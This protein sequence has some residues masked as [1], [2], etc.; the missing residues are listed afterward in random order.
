MHFICTDI[1][2][3]SLHESTNS[4]MFANSQNSQNSQNSSQV[5]S[6]S[7][8]DGNWFLTQLNDTTVEL[9]HKIAI[10]Q[11]LLDEQ[12]VQNDIMGEEI[13][14]KLRSAIGKANLLIS[15]KFNQFRELCLKN[16]VRNRN[17][18]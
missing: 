9:Q 1:G 18:I 11:K 16:I 2:M 3:N 13:A 15:Q 12:Y 14:G 17:T 8:H 10:T 4:E 7:A 6:L 5:P